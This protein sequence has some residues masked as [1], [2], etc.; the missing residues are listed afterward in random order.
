MRR[1]RSKGGSVWGSW[2]AE[3]EEEEA[4]SPTC[5]AARRGRASDPQHASTLMGR[6]LCPK[7]GAWWPLGLDTSWGERMPEL[8]QPMCPP[9]GAHVPVLLSPLCTWLWKKFKGSG[10]GK[11]REIVGTDVRPG[12]QREKLG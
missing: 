12:A 3:G 6:V 2:A 4:S 9:V 10:G 1:R 5:P 8:T 7:G 11:A